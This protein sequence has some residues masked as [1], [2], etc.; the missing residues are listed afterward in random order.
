[1]SQARWHDYLRDRLLAFIEESGA[2]TFV[3]D[4][5]VPYDGLVRA[6][7][8]LPDVAFVWMRRG[9][10]R[11][12]V[13]TAPLRSSVCFDAVLE[14]GDIAR[15]GDSGATSAL[16]DAVRLPPISLAEHVDALSREDAAA[17]LGLNPS[18]PTALVTLS[19]GALNDVAAPGGAAVAALLRHP[20]W[21]VAVT[22][23]ALTQGGIPVADRERCVELSGVYPLVRYLRAFDAAVAAGGYNSVHELLYA[24]IPTLF[25]PNRSS[26]TDDQVART[27]WLADNGLALLAD[28]SELDVVAARAVRLHDA[29]VR[30]ELSAA[31]A[32]LARPTGSAAAAKELLALTGGRGSW[33][34]NGGKLLMARQSARA[35]AIRALGPRAEALARKALRRAPAPGPTSP[36][37]VRV[38]SQPPPSTG[39]VTPLLL[40][41]ELDADSLSAGYPVEHLLPGS[42]ASYR[43]RRLAIAGRYY[44]LTDG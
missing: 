6:R 36:L 17:A 10:W 34:P 4:G 43:E 16:T 40:T 25:V 1:M 29:E 21:Q 27:R 31:C 20:D 12:G 13:R 41:E 32:T 24:G 38:H 14:P 42:S 33:A 3:F 30:A 44:K 39:G 9:F 7:R 18:R 11:A 2:D 35:T 23:T 5:V 22:R 8:K 19:S 15:A 28:E 26:G 37:L